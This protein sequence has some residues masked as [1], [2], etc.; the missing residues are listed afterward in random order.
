[1]IYKMKYIKVNDPREVYRYRKVEER[2][3]KLL[4]SEE[5]D[6]SVL[7]FYFKS[8]VELSVK[9]VNRAYAYYFRPSKNKKRKLC[10]ITHG[11]GERGRTATI[12]FAREL[13]R[14]GFPAVFLTLPF[15]GKR[16]VEGIAE[17]E[18]IFVL[19]SVGMLMRF[20]QAVSDL[21]TLADFAERGLF[22][23]IDE[24][25]VLGLS[26]GGMIATVA[27]GVDERFKKGVFILAGGDIEGIFWKSFS[28]RLMRKYVYAV[29]KNQ[30]ISRER[31]E[32][33][34]ISR[35]YDPLTFAEFIPPREVI[36]FNGYLD[37]IIPGFA[38]RKLFEKI[39]TARITYLPFGHG[40]I[41]AFRKLMLHRIIRFLGG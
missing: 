39:S 12:Y 4:I 21:R 7:E 16:Q 37:P 3:V 8:P 32:Y 9:E 24:I 2:P 20:R 34:N 33:A 27:M 6:F 22:G 26:I 23:E 1:M 38:S 25:S 14:A 17:G 41:L 28:M 40:T 35:L 18:G 11:H 36:M 30:D 31:E 29:A 19:D 10:I 5:E 15:H 13:A